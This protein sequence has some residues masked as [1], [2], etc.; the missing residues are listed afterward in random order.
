MNAKINYICTRRFTLSSSIL[1]PLKYQYLSNMDT[2]ISPEEQNKALRHQLYQVTQEKDQLQQEIDQVQQEKHQL[3]QENDQVQQEKDQLQQQLTPLTFDSLLALCHNEFAQVQVE[4][5]KSSS[6]TGGVGNPHDKLLPQTLRHWTGFPTLQESI[7]R[8]V[9]TIYHQYKEPPATFPNSNFIIKGIKSRQRPLASELDLRRQQADCVEDIVE[10]VIKDLIKEREPPA[11]FKLGS[12]IE[13]NNHANNLSQNEVKIL[14]AKIADKILVRKVEGNTKRLVLIVEYKPPHKLSIEMLKAGL[15]D[16]DLS[17]LIHRSKSSNDKTINSIEKSEDVLAIVIAQIYTYMIDSGIQYAY[18]TTGEAFVFLHTQEQDRETLYY[19]MVIPKDTSTS[20]ATN[21]ISNTAIG[22]V[23]SFYILACG[24][25]FYDQDTR[26]RHREQAMQWRKDEDRLMDGMTPS[27]Q[28]PPTPSS[29]YKSHAKRHA[30]AHSQSQTTRRLRSSTSG[31]TPALNVQARKDDSDDSPDRDDS[32]APSNP[33]APASTRASNRSRDTSSRSTNK[34]SQTSN[35]TSS[36]SRKRHENYCTHQCLLGLLNKGALDPSCPNYEFH[37]KRGNGRGKK[38]HAISVEELH[39]LLLAQIQRTMNT[40]IEPLG[41][42]GSRGAIFKLTLES[43]G[44]TMIGKGTPPHYVADLKIERRVYDL[45]HRLQG[46]VIPVCLGAIDSPRRY[47]YDLDVNIYHWLLISFAGKSLTQAEFD[48]H[49]PS[50]YAM[51]DNLLRY[52]IKHPDISPNNILWDERAKQLM[53]IDFERS[54]YIK[55]T[56]KEVEKEE[57][58]QD[59]QFLEEM[60]PNKT[61]EKRKEMEDGEDETVRPEKL[62]IQWFSCIHTN[63]RKG[64]PRLLFFFYF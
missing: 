3:Q 41:L 61:L 64:D 30:P 32:K 20:E 27:P 8:K 45:L 55:Q 46:T 2:G 38:R 29:S 15:K 53:V 42:E 4:Q 50:A 5:D 10:I 47:F 40:N 54:F 43:H 52:G 14:I 34:A 44:Y 39:K 37:P 18:L 24:G 16:L 9:N 26:D 28:K 62:R 59:K 63:M 21:A 13:I 19:H 7:F 49:K 11:E 51:A 57:K 1:F 22:Q 35:E 33:F 48:A 60:S 58:P 23:I 25:K 36:S 12:D 17:N 56:E 6:T 31:E